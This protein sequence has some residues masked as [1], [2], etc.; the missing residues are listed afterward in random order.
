[1]ILGTQVVIPFEEANLQAYKFLLR[2]EIALRESLRISLTEQFGPKWRNRLPGDLLKKVREAQ[3]EETQ[4]QFDYLCL[5]PLYYLTL[6]EL[7]P[8]LQQKAGRTTAELFG[9]DCF[10]KQ[11]ENI[12]GPRNAICHGRQVP[13]AGLKAIEALYQQMETALTA[14]GFSDLISKPDVGLLQENAA[15][16]LIPWMN[17]AKTVISNLESSVAIA[18]VYNL[19]QEQYW[20]GAR[21]LAGFDCSLIDQVAYLINDYNSLPQGV[22]SASSRQRFCCERRPIEVIE[23]AITTLKA[24]AP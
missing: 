11:V 6:G 1:M 13:S 12:L 10:I 3:K 5:G 19:A 18:E 2:I 22:G 8:I 23:N 20:W 17:H 15:R 4:P 7:V 16:D 24:V 9:G 21:E 14:K